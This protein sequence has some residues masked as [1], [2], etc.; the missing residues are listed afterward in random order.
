MKTFQSKPTYLIA[1]LLLFL[2]AC[3][4]QAREDLINE[5][6]AGVTVNI[7][8]D[9]FDFPVVIQLTDANPENDPIPAN[10]DLRVE[11]PDKDQ[12][13]SPA[14]H[15]NLQV[16]NGIVEVAVDKELDIS[17]GNPLELT[18]IAEAP[19]YLK[20]VKQV[21]LYDTT[22]QYQE[23]PMVNLASLPKGVSSVEGSFS[24][25]TDGA[26]QKVEVTSPL[27]EGKEE[28]ATVTVRQGTK[29]FNA[30]GQELQG[31]VDIQLVHFD[32]RSPESVNAFPGG[33]TAYSVI[34]ENGELIEPIE[35]VTAG[36]IALDM[37]V[38]NKEVKTFSQP[39]E[40]SVGISRATINPN[41]N[42]TVQVGDEIPIWSLDDETGQWKYEGV[43]AVSLVNEGQLMATFEVTH[44]SWWNLDYRV[45]PFC[46]KASPVQFNIRSRF[47]GDDAPTYYSRLY[48]VNTGLYFSNSNYIRIENG[49]AHYLYN[50]PG[51]RM[52]SLHL[53]EY[54]NYSC[55]NL[56]HE[57]S[58]FTTTCND[59]V[60]V[61]L[62]SFNPPQRDII[63]VYATG[64]CDVELGNINDPIVKPDVLIFYRTAGC[65]VFN[66][67]GEFDKGYFRTDKLK[68]G[69][70]YDFQVNIGGESY[71]FDDITI[72]SGQIPFENGTIDI[73]LDDLIDGDKAV[74]RF[75]NIQIPEAY[76]ESIT[77]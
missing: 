66:V 71:R 17:V 34:D 39:V 14:G 60:E 12:V 63:E 9:I 77:G 16:V 56:V 42:Q 52:F 44:L 27:T 38:G 45:E 74:L 31:E 24:A 68:H 55:R 48:D 7:N 40:I 69:L 10:L 70:T 59:E 23:V 22:F 51:N 21:V 5:A 58:P 47:E 18:L 43:A 1:S 54:S 33:M 30:N 73:N 28:A 20:T 41:T 26:S 3:T 6:T 11:G 67:L 4:Q 2:G 37:Y 35:F 29:V 72:Q 49:K 76:C 50:I 62:F 15:R 46:N 53:F 25:G 61:D 32:N 13:Y 19:G 8:T 64:A 75:D 36:F 65:K 57:S